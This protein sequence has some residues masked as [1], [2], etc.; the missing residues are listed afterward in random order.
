MG[1]SF[2]W[3]LESLGLMALKGFTSDEVLFWAR[4]VKPEVPNKQASN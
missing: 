4:L 2:P 1:V 3:V